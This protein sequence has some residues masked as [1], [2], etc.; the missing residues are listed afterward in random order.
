MILEALKQF[1]TLEKPGDANNPVIIAWA[2]ET[3]GTVENV[4]KTDRL[5]GAASLWLLL[6][7]EPAI[8]SCWVML[9][10]VSGKQPM[11]KNR[12]YVERR[13]EY[14]KQPANV[15]KIILAASGA[16]SNNEQ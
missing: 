11:A 3:G 4:Y 5:P 8:Y 13:P 12:L 10:Y 2:H 1:G 15:R 14:S 6:H 7:K 9:W 16:L